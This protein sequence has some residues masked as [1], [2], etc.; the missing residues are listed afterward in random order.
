MKRLY[1]WRENASATRSVKVD[2]VPPSQNCREAQKRKKARK[3]ATHCE[4]IAFRVLDT[5]ANWKN[6]AF[7][8]NI[9]RLLSSYASTSIR[10]DVA[11]KQAEEE[12]C[13]KES[14]RAEQFKAI[15]SSPRSRLESASRGSRGNAGFIV[16]WRRKSPDTGRNSKLQ[17]FFASTRL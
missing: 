7:K 8:G 17:T 6:E 4:K 10:L 11:E 13:E 2:L 1:K 14:E 15:K 12:K 9:L 16:G 3:K 5:K